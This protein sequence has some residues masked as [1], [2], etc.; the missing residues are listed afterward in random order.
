MS[1]DT[2]PV[3]C[4]RAAQ[5]AARIARDIDLA[6][7]LTPMQRRI[8]KPGEVLYRG[9]QVLLHVFLVST[10]MFRCASVSAD[11]RGQVVGFHGRG[12]WLGLESVA[13][14]VHACETVA[15]DTS[16]VLFVP[17]ERLLVACAKAPAL[18]RIVHEA[19][20]RDL[21]RHRE[22]LMSIRT[23]GADARV[24]DFLFTW[25]DSMAACGLRTDQIRLRMTRAEIASFLGLALESV[26]RA[27]SRLQQ[28][29]LIRFDRTSRREIRIPRLQALAAF[30]QGSAALATPSAGPMVGPIADRA[31]L[32]PVRPPLRARLGRP[33]GFRTHDQTIM[34]RLL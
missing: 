6:A 4:A 10:G 30:A 22:Q 15:L 33:G 31:P 18:L 3:S 1:L 8:A 27:L 21:T 34:S 2:D 19:M 25:A 24:A 13:Q 29:D 28:Q 32:P 12:C 5:R 16:E 26:S 11:G 23:L 17:Y 20:S 9:G 7:E 14:G